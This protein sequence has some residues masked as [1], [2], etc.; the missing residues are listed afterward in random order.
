MS[1]LQRLVLNHRII[2]IV[3]IHVGIAIISLWLAF[4]LRF[5]F[6][7]PPICVAI[8]WK[9]LPL[10]VAS[11]LMSYWP[12]GLFSGMWRYVTVQDV[13]EMLKATCLGALL[14]VL[15]TFILWHGASMPRSVVFLSWT[16]CFGLS[17]DAIY[18]VMGISP[19]AVIG[20]ASEALPSWLKVSSSI[21][22][23]LLSIRPF[24]EFFKKTFRS[25]K[26]QPTY[27]S[28]FPPINKTMKKP[29][30]QLHPVKIDKSYDST[31]K[32]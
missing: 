22:L 28:D 4:A 17:V 5:D 31:K 21:V 11:M 3:L 16:I 30:N 23:A 2:L 10:Y 18:Q 32:K 29:E 6:D 7:I 12:F 15:G 20:E 14:F 1:R 19:A 8:F 24:Y 9:V 25:K 13:E 27:F 26:S